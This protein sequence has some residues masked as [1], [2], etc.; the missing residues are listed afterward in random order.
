MEGRGGGGG[1]G[2]EFSGILS[3]GVDCGTGIGRVTAGFLSSV[4]EV[5]DAVEPIESFAAKARVAD[6]KGPGRVG[7]VYVVGL[8]DWVPEGR[9]DV[10][11]AQWCLGY[12]RDGQVVEFLRRCKGVLGEGGW[13]VVKENVVGQGGDCFDEGDRSVTRSEE[14]WRML[15]REAGLRVVRGEWQRGFPRGIYGVRMW[16]LRG[17]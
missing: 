6:M 11:W 10:I 2:G 5:V 4:C 1:G 15:F 13:V 8:Q 3:R 9:Y 16:G 17:A 14:K 12:L 7:E